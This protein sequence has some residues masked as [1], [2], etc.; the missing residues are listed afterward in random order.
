M[1]NYTIMTPFTLD[2]RLVAPR[3][4]ETLEYFVTPEL[5][6]L[7]HKIT[8]GKADFHIGSFFVDPGA[9][10]KFLREI[11]P[12]RSQERIIEAFRN[13]E[14]SA[15]FTLDEAATLEKTFEENGFIC[16][17]VE[18]FYNGNKATLPDLPPEEFSKMVKECARLHMMIPIDLEHDGHVMENMFDEVQDKVTR[19]IMKE[20]VDRDAA[21]RGMTRKKLTI[22][23]VLS[24]MLLTV[25][26]GLFAL[27]RKLFTKGGRM[28]VIGGVTCSIVSM[29]TGI[30]G[31][32]LAEEAVDY[33]RKGMIA[34]YA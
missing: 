21:R 16:R 24:G 20:Q 4:Y 11:M 3:D 1:K 10:D 17:R 23:C 6:F 14:I 32:K 26:T 13:N 29:V 22:R 28:G 2:W 31:K 7:F 19:R 33:F 9:H 27:G 30:L 25:S 34:A 12:Q 18:I 15:F 8:N 5:S